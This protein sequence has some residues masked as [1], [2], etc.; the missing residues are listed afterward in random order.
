MFLTRDEITD[1]VCRG[2]LCEDDG[3]VVAQ[4]CEEGDAGQQK[5][6]PPG[7]YLVNLRYSPKHGYAVP[8]IRGV[9]HYPNAEIHPGNSV[10]D[11]EGCVLVGASRGP[12][13]CQDGVTRDGVLTSRDTFKALMQRWGWGAYKT[14][15]DWDDVKAFNDAL[16]PEQ[17]SFLLEVLE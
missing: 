10:L 7:K 15:R 11:T 6:F 14:L 3:T 16:P 4:T 12:V 5:R 9:P 8:G 17:R 1:E 2:T 13:E